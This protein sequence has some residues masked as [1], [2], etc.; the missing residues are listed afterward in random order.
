MAE[1]GC[2]TPP[3]GCE[4]WVDDMHKQLGSVPL[5]EAMT[6][7][8]AALF[9]DPERGLAWIANLRRTASQMDHVCKVGT[10]FSGCDIIRHV[11]QSA[12]AFWLHTYDIRLDFQMVFWA[13]THRDKQRF[14][15]DH[16][17]AQTIGRVSLLY[18]VWSP[19]CFVVTLA[20]MPVC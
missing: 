9:K 2:E 20:C 3:A 16:R 1:P 19:I 10:M 18:E 15:L 6:A 17:G 14:L 4:T 8:H 11:L 12:S 5:T 13:E 7:W